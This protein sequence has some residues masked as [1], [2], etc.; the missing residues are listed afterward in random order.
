ML[1]NIKP[2]IIKKGGMI[3][4]SVP[5]KTT[6]EKQ[7]PRFEIGLV[8]LPEAKK[9]PVGETY[10][11]EMEVEMVGLRMSEHKDPMMS[12]D[13]NNRAEFEIKKIGSRNSEKGKPDTK[14]Y[15]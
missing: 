7:Y 1:R 15:T 10:R 6:T 8:H 2:K 9:W 14:R 5:A 11:I 13:W 12:D 4:E 3:A